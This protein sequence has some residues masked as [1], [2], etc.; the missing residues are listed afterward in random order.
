EGQRRLW[1]AF[2]LPGPRRL[3]KFSQAR[4]SETT[5]LSVVGK[6]DPSATI[7]KGGPDSHQDDKSTHEWVTAKRRAPG[8]RQTSHGRS[9]PWFF[10]GWHDHS[11]P[12]SHPGTR[13]P[14]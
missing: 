2:I 3:P 14:G 9:T 6:I 5:V 13:T 4:E 12:T 1:H 8:R 7:R 11:Q 10:A